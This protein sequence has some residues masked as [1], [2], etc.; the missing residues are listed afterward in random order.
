[1][2]DCY[3]LV[4]NYSKPILICDKNDEF[5]SMLKDML[6]K[7]GFFHLIEALSTKEALE[8]LRG[9]N[10]V[11]TL[12]TA[13][14]ITSEIVDFFKGTNS[15]LIFTDSSDPSTVTLAAKLGVNHMMSYPFH[16]QKLIDKMNSLN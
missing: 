1:M 10:E 6:T 16:S 4:M 13:K 15:Y 3:H 7:N 11:F 2:P 12:I 9:K 14:D 8:I 5:R